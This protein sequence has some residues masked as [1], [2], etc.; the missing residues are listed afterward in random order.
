VPG[1]SREAAPSA[2]T[3]KAAGT[4]KLGRWLTRWW[5]RAPDGRV[6]QRRWADVLV[7]AAG[8]GLVIMCGVLVA[9]QLV[10]GTDVAL[11]HRVNH[12]PGWLYPPMWVV[13]LSGVIGALPLLAA[14]AALLRR[15]RLAAALAA[16][17]LL[18]IWLESVAKM[19][20]QRGRPAETVPDVILRGNSAAH[21]LSFPSGHAMV[22]FAA[23]ALVA[24]YLKGWWKALPWTLAAAVCLSRLYLGAH[25]PLDVIAGAG[26]G[27]FI[28]GVLNLVL[29]VPRLPSI[30]QTPAETRP[31]PTAPQG[32]RPRRASRRDD[33]RAASNNAHS[34]MI[35]AR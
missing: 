33:F 3:G 1:M 23:T 21:G 22:I 6:Y 14:A 29:G 11:L 31:L 32:N 7:P 2:G 25:F 24:P 35:C 10:A 5:I 13:Q 30:P 15:F 27:M 28:G 26:L 4:G 18:K 12:W 8:L 34:R 20:V 9:N 17:A 16:A 19:L